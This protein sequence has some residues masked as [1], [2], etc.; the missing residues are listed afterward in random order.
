MPTYRIESEDGD[1]TIVRTEKAQQSWDEATYW[2]GNNHI[3]KATG[4]Q[5]EHE[6]LY[7]SAK[8]NYYV[9]HTNQWQ[10]STPAAAFV[11]AQAAVLWLL[12]NDHDLP[13][14][15]KAHEDEVSE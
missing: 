13:D 9:E 3:S 5:R 10:G 4:S 15:L 1:T 6:T 11:T 12:A 8:G 14:A 7:L 2:N